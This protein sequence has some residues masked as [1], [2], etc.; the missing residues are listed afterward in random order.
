MYI[1]SIDFGTSSVKAAIVNEKLETLAW[2]K[3]PYDFNVYDTDKVELDPDIVFDG[4]IQCTKQMQEHLDKVELITYDT[5]SPSVVLMDEKGQALYPIITHLDRRSRK[6]TQEILNK[7]GEDKFQQITG[8]L[9]FTGGASLTSMMWMNENEPEIFLNTHKIG[10]FN[11]YIY[12]KLTGLWATD[13]VNASMMG[14]Y[15]TV[16]DTSWSKEI[17]ETFKIPMEKLPEIHQSGTILGTL[18]KEIAQQLNL[19]EGIP[20]SLG[21]NDAATAQVGAGNTKKGD[22]LV[23]SGSSEMVSILTDKPVVNKNYYLRRAATPGM[24][25]IFAITVGGFA[26]DW[27]RKEF[28]SEMDINHFY[29]TY[30]PEVIQN[31]LESKTVEFQPYLAGD[32]QSLELKRGGFTGLTLETTRENMLVSILIGMHNPVT[33]TIKLTQEFLNLNNKIKITGG[34]TG[35]EYIDLKEKILQGFNF[36]TVDDCPIKGNVILAQKFTT[37]SQNSTHSVY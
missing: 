30:L 26:I 4:L 9:P 28:Y 20:V 2:A 6:Q 19:K 27:F 5:F 13:Y 22:I 21:G 34:L 14:L 25:Q 7:M 17:C 37:I 11:T 15:E 36:E 16:K 1:L 10:H 29:Q 12:K 23:I 18:Q 24:W 8:I 32:R 35:K 33:E 31:R 3:S